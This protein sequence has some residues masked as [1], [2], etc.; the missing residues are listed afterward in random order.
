[1]TFVAF[2]A[3]FLLMQTGVSLL[4]AIS[5]GPVVA[6][7]KIDIGGGRL[8]VR[9]SLDGAGEEVTQL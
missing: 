1:M 4:F 8:M 7:T 5:Q 3:A 2:S 6:L 9:T